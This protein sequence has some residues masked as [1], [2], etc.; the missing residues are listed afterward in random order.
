MQS[1][2]KRRLTAQQLDALLRE[3]AG[4]GC[5]LEAELTDGWFNTAYRVLLDDGRPAVVKLAPPAE[6]PVLRYERG[7]MNTEA[8]VYRRVGADPAG[9]PMPELLFAGDDFLAI[10][11]LEGTPWD[12][13]SDVLPATAQSALRHELGRITARL[14][15]LKAEDGSFG[16]PAP[17][18]GLSAPDWRGAFT[19]MVEAIL[20]DAARW[21]SP[22][23][24]SPADVRTLV[25][26]GGYALDEVTEPRLV[27]FD[28]WPG[29]VFVD[30][31]GA[32]VTGL[33][34]HERAFWGDP[35]AELISLA[36]GGD[37]GPGSALVTGY[38]EAGGQLGS[39][40][41]LQ[42]RLALYRLYLGLILVVECG[43]RGYDTERLAHCR[44]T[45]DGWVSDLRELG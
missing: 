14:H 35:A 42:H 41:A 38:T 2:T 30:G 15:S 18:S 4:T 21:E 36:F 5:R 7:I 24:I 9:I 40:P 10:S 28:L 31:S 29:N 19:A 32:R 45:L 11:V 20:D 3:S 26:E 37:T 8:M 16:Y 17:E 13:V 6:V 1:Q 39:G 34:D 43:P 27:H 23:G 44:G 12:T 33:I 25:A 22:L